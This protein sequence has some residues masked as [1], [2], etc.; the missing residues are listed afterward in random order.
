MID[1]MIFLFYISVYVSLLL[2]CYRGI[3]QEAK[4][5]IDREELSKWDKLF[6]AYLNVGLLDFKDVLTYQER[7]ESDHIKS[8]IILSYSNIVFWVGLLWAVIDIFGVV[9]YGIILIY[10]GRMWSW[11]TF[12]IH[13]WIT[14]VISVFVSAPFIIFIVL[15]KQKL[16]ETVQF[17]HFERYLMGKMYIDNG[18][19]L[20][21][22]DPPEAENLK[23]IK[24]FG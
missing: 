11:D 10:T 18:V 7:I 8:H 20:T 14:L 13:G 12:D 4:H 9:I 19:V 24:I 2:V 3:R 23:K 15:S 5:Y 17:G 6:D 1:I 21:L 22:E 16:F